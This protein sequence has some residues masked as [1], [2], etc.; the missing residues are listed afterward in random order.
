V[1]RRKRPASIRIA[2]KVYR[3]KFRQETDCGRCDNARLTIT[4]SRDQDKQHQRDTLLH[5]VIHAV[6]YACGMD[7]GEENVRMLGTHLLAALVENPEATRW[8]LDAD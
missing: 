3:V 4:I 1:T 7:I 8:I 5:E 2:G 6:E